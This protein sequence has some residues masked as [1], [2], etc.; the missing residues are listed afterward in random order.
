[1]VRQLLEQYS[2]DDIRIL[3]LSHHHTEPW[4]Y[5]KQQLVASDWRPS[6]E[7]ASGSTMKSDIPLTSS[8]RARFF[9][10]GM[11]RSTHG[12]RS[13]PAVFGDKILRNRVDELFCPR[14]DGFRAS[15][16][17]RWLT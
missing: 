9:S 2:S 13:A 10:A 15:C 1:M 3:L 5:N 11:I 6:V 17:V 12:A 4:S 16:A 7:T 8:K 14:V